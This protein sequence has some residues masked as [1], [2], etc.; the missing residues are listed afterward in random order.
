MFSD[1]VTY[2]PPNK[3]PEKHEVWA[4][5]LHHCLV[6]RGAVLDYAHVDTLDG[7]LQGSCCLGSALGR[8]PDGRGGKESRAGHWG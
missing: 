1:A 3:S 4:Y 7:V 2:N 8:S 6:F 5:C